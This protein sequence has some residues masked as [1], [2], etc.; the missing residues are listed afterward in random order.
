M[1]RLAEK[2]INHTTANL[3]PHC[4]SGVQNLKRRRGLTLIELSIVLLI[5]VILIPILFSVASNFSTLRSSETEADSLSK[6]YTFARRAA[7]KSGETV[8][9]ELNFEENYYLLYRLNRNDEEIEKKPILDKHSL[10][11]R[12]GLVAVVSP[13]GGRVN[14]GVVTL[15]FFFDGTTEEVSIYLGSDSIIDKTV[16]FPRFSVSAKVENGETLPEALTGLENQ[17][18]DF[19]KESSN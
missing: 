3:V 18:M 16:Y 12:N 1:A 6:I 2:E 13:L 11:S 4:F 9:L 10:A 7:I 17:D 5:F 15:P 8:Y 14:S 19:L